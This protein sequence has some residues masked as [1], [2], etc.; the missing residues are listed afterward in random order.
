MTNVI[1]IKPN[2]EGLNSAQMIYHLHT[3]CERLQQVKGEALHLEKLLHRD[4]QP[5]KQD[6]LAR[7]ATRQMIEL[8]SPTIDVVLDAVAEMIVETAAELIAPPS[9]SIN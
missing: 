9:P 3:L 8:L 6:L 7:D 1:P 2:V 4:R 5:T